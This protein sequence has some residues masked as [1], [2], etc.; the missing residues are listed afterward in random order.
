MDPYGVQATSIF[1]LKYIPKL[2]MNSNVKYL[3]I[4]KLTLT[5]L[6]LKLLF[7]SFVV[8]FCRHELG[9]AIWT[10]WEYQ[11]LDE[12]HL[13]HQRSIIIKYISSMIWYKHIYQELDLELFNIQ[14]AIMVETIC[15]TIWW[16][17]TLVWLWIME[18]L[19]YM[20]S[21]VLIHVYEVL[22]LYS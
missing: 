18:N 17:Y 13:R 7:L 12:H 4:E 14:K 10:D 3:Y 6:C 5:F 19:S 20:L 21:N 22:P 11:C 2:V 16:H 9:V 15:T 1:E 8:P